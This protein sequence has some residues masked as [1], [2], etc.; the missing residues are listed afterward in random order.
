LIELPVWPLP[1]WLPGSWF[2][3]EQHLYRHAG[4][5]YGWCFAL[6]PAEKTKIVQSNW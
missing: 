4:L 2:M 5:D 1:G 3:V 6:P